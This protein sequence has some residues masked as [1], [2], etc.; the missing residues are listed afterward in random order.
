MR[1]VNI[2][3]YYMKKDTSLG[4]PICHQ[5]LKVFAPDRRKVQLAN[6]EIHAG[7]SAEEKKEETNIR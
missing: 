6:E 1:G 3:Y 7:T 2:I 4:S 5:W